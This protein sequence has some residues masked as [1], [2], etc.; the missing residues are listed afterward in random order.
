MFGS[1][2]HNN[3]TDLVANTIK[4]LN[5]KLLESI[6]NDDIWIFTRKKSKERCPQCWDAVRRQVNKDDCI[7]CFGSGYKDGYNSP[8]K[9]KWNYLSIP[10]SLQ[11]VVE[12]VEERAEDPAINVWVQVDV[13][14]EPGDFIIDFKNNRFYIESV[15]YTTKNNSTIIRQ[16]LNIKRVSKDDIVYQLQIPQIINIQGKISDIK[17]S[18]KVDVVEL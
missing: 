15:Q 8:I 10:E 9:T 12:Y 14:L 3:S 4:Y 5:S 17:T 13:K 7:Y 11:H 1:I 2:N 16:I 6:N 18:I